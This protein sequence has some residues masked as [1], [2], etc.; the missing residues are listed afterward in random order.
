MHRALSVGYGDG[1]GNYSVPA[2]VHVHVIGT[3]KKDTFKI[4]K[5]QKEKL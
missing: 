3:G 4:E 1:E 2:K 5:N